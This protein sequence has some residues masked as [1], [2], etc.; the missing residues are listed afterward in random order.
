MKQAYGEDTITPLIFPAG[1]P[2]ANTSSG[3]GNAGDWAESDSV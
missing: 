3:R 2:M 1:D